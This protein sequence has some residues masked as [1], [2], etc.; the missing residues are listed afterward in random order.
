MLYEVITSVGIWPAWREGIALTV[1]G[2]G[3]SW[4]NP[5]HENTAGNL[6]R[7]A[8]HARQTSQSFHF[9]HFADLDARHRARGDG[10]DRRA[11]VV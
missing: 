2:A 8:L 11:V 3:H 6:R 4:F 9:L 1:V 7:P 5:P 10:V